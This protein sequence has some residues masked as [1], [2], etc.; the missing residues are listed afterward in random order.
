MQNNAENWVWWRIFFP[1]ILVIQLCEHSVGVGTTMAASLT[2][3]LCDDE[4]QINQN[5]KYYV[6]SIRIHIKQLFRSGRQ[7]HS[8][9]ASERTRS[10]LIV[11]YFIIIIIVVVNFAITMLIVAGT[12]AAATVDVV[13]V[14]CTWNI[15]GVFTDNKSVCKLFIFSVVNIEKCVIHVT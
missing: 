12:A 3:C 10:F 5:A 2:R 15:F 11:L 13:V 6:Y 9:R 1:L 14:C 8:K 7:T 4:I